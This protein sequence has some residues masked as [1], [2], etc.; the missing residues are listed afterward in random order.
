MLLPVPHEFIAARAPKSA[1]ECADICANSPQRH[2]AATTEN[3]NGAY[4]SFAFVATETHVGREIPDEIAFPLVLARLK[5]HLV[6]TERGCWYSHHKPHS[7][8]GYVQVNFRGKRELLHRLS[9]RIHKGPIPDGLNVLH[10][11][12][13][14]R[15][16]NP[17]HLWLG[18]ISDNKQ[19]ELKKG[20]NYEASRTHCP[21]GHAY[22]E[23]AI[24]A[25]KEHPT[26][27]RCA[28]CDKARH[29]SPE[30]M[31]RVREYQRR[32]RAAKR[33]SRQ[34]RRSGDSK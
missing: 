5:K 32:R 14:R 25:H 17:E 27:R 18:T 26:W 33:E 2:R 22:A 6:V 34:E 8:F 11:C 12:D 23:H 4:V 20:R 7:R 28:L 13:D 9:F 24:Y 21:K 29:K 1:G 31:A 3:H 16:W 10:E 19:D 15:C 30:N